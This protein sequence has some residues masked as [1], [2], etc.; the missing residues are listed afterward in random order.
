[1]V[2]NL[3]RLR[4]EKGFSQKEMADKLNIAPS[5]YFRYEKDGEPNIEKLKKIAICLDTTLDE[6]CGMPKHKQ[7][8]DEDL[9]ELKQG[10]A[11]LID[12]LTKKDIDKVLKYCSSLIIEKNK[13]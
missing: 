9:E 4:E 13:E 11:F 10:L 7:N 1:M 3:K 2:E 6:L 8:V 5:A 12:H